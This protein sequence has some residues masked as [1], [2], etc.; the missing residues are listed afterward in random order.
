M[1]NRELKDII[2]EIQENEEL[3]LNAIAEKAKIDRSYLSTFINAEEVKTVTDK[4]LSKFKRNFPEYFHAKQQKQHIDTIDANLKEIL[5]HTRA[6]LTG[7]T[8]DHQIIMRSLDRLEKNPEGTLSELADKL[9]MQI[10][11]RLNH[12]DKGM[13]VGKRT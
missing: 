1:N 3:G 2:E 12:P 10:Q 5:R 4:M 6:L 7:Q 11:Q 13:Q 8:A 9:A